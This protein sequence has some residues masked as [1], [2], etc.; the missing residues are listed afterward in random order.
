MFTMIQ[1][2]LI[3]VVYDSCNLALK[4]VGVQQKFYAFVEFL[5]FYVILS[6]INKSM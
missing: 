2:N 3:R 6:S 5:W 4:L 1:M